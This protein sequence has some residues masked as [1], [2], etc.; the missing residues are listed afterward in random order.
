DHHRARLVDDHERARAL[1]RLAADI[2]G[3]RVVAPETNIVMFDIERADL[4]AEGLVRALDAHGVRMVEFTRR[5]VRAVTHLD[6]D[7]DDIETAAGALS[8]VLE[9]ASG[10][11]RTRNV[12]G[13][14]NV[15]DANR[16]PPSGLGD[17][18][19]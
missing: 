3:L 9:P 12:P 8:A 16:A 2:P 15:R 14:A 10:R 1:A 7:D 5:R 13:P 11:P 17:F 6:I 19:L 4:D 18:S